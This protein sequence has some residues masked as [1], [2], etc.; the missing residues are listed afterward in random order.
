MN[1]RS[2]QRWSAALAVWCAT[3]SLP[4]TL[5]A[6][7]TVARAFDLERRGDY[8]AAAEAYQK[9]L[10]ADP[11]DVTAL[12]GFERALLPLDRVGEVLPFVR[13]TLKV[14]S[15][16][17][18]V[19]GIG[20]RAF[21]ALGMW[22]SVAALAGRWS[23][24]LP[25]DETPFREWGRA[26][27][28]VNDRDAARTAYET[29]R[30][31]LASPSALAGELAV[32]AIMERDFVTAAREWVLAASDLPGYRVSALNSL[33]QVPSADR[34]GVLAQLQRDTLPLARQLAAQLQARWGDPVG[35]F[36]R[37][38]PT[39][40][41][42]PARGNEALRQFLDQ[43]RGQRS[44]KARRAEGMVYEALAAR[45]GGA[46]AARMRLE[47]A[48]AYAEGNDQAAARRMLAQ[49]ASDRSAPTELV[50]GAT[51]TLIGVLVDEGAVAE[52]EQRLEEVGA[53][54]GGEA[55]LELRRKIARGWLKRGRLDDAERLLTADSSVAGLA[56]RGY[57]RLYRGDL[58]GAVED[59]TAA[60]P[61]AG[62]RDEA[63]ARTSLLAL[64]QPIEGDTLPRL[65]EGLLA[66]ELGDTT[67]ALAVLQE[68]ASELPPA[69]GG[70]ELSLLAGKV[71]RV[72][73]RT[74]DAERLF[75]SA[76]EASTSAAAPAGELE[77]G[78]LLLDLSRREEAVAQLEH[79]IITY[80]TSAVVPQARRLLDQARG[81]IPRT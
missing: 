68:V 15:T 36:E 35:G 69:K 40:P 19:Y 66:L 11:A 24:R 4:G 81:A 70:G 1:A 52:A 74:A 60:G 49:L 50:A 45:S 29:G 20:L 56:A 71:A 14:D 39:V 18:A 26:A 30:R 73:G 2:A 58:T 9:V 48:Q 57:V 28:R 55:Y 44:T 7:A 13:A 43:L 72:A 61:F 42:D 77:L 38:L 8:A 21:A 62:T 67:K 59:F 32:L 5:G 6:Q 10:A 22:D 79:L 16:T 25:D 65:G 64:L 17:G 3:L 46:Q 75:R 47:A 41:D 63:A 76:A 78:R 34:K 23:D 53:A 37:F 51:S 80:P 12:L 33:G 54:L 31:H 27:L